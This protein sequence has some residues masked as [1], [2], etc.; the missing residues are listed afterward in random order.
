MEVTPPVVYDPAMR[1]L[2]WFSCGAASAALAKIVCER[3]PDAVPVYC[4]TSASEHPDGLRFMRDVEEWIGR[5]VTRIASEKYTTVED[6]FTAR[7]YMAGIA[8]APCT[9]ALKKVPRFCFQK[10]HDTHHFGLTADETHRIDRFEGN[11]PDMILEW[12]LRDQ[13]ITKAECLR[14]V[15]D[16]GIEMH[17][18]YRLGYR[19]ANCLGCVK[20][21]SPAYWQRIRADFP[22]VFARRVK[23]SRELGVRLARLHGE[24][25]FIDELPSDAPLLPYIDE[26]VSCG[27]ECADAGGAP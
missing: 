14:R 9:V 17:A 27:P 15:S 11:N 2:I 22:D 25:V 8:G 19:N 5:K 1:H 13:G 4:D 16:A 12:V 18:M 6:V 20:A 10:A 24:R 23:Q 26:N 3:E 21:Q 7:R